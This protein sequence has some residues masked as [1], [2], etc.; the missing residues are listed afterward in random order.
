M[1]LLC[2]SILGRTL[3]MVTHSLQP[4]FILFQYHSIGE[5][6]LPALIAMIS[7]LIGCHV[8]FSAPTNQAADAECDALQKVA[9]VLE[10]KQG[11]IGIGQKCNKPWLRAKR[12]QQVLGG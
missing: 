5:S 1:I 11:N 10:V 6:L 9:M 4:H 7:R 12:R 2:K 3:R 8:V